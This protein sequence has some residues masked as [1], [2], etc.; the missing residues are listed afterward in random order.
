VV[1]LKEAWQ[2]NGEDLNALTK[3]GLNQTLLLRERQGDLKRPVIRLIWQGG[4]GEVNQLQKESA[5]CAPN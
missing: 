1:L 5:L 4:R 2:G 3:G